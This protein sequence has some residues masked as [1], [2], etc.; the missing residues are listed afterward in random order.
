[1]ASSSVSSQ[2]STITASSS[3]QHVINKKKT[4]TLILNEEAFHYYPAKQP[5][6]AAGDSPLKF[7]FPWTSISKHQVS[8]ASHAKNLLRVLSDKIIEGG[9]NGKKKSTIA[10][11]YEFANRA[12][13]ERIRKDISTRLV[14]S[15]RVQA[16]NNGSLNNRAS[17]IG[18]NQSMS[19]ENETSRKRKLDATNTSESSSPGIGM[20][21]DNRNAD[22][23]SSFTSL[24]QSERTVTCSSILASDQNVRTQ[25]TSLL[26]KAPSATTSLNGNGSTKDS[27]KS[28]T[29]TI[30]EQDFWST[31]RQKLSN[32]SAKI[33]GFV[34][35]GVSS[36][37][38]SSLEIQITGNIS[39]P[40]KLGVEEMR[41]IFI[42][43]PAVHAAYEQ[44]VPL[45]LSE[46]QFWR[47][48]LESEYFHR[49]RGRMG[50]SAKGVDAAEKSREDQ[51]DDGTKKSKDGTTS[52]ADKKLAK[53]EENKAAKEREETA[54]MG[55]A[56]SNDIFSRKD[57]EL[58]RRDAYNYASTSQSKNT[59]NHKQSTKH[60]A[61]G[62]FDLTTTANTERGTK[63]L[64]QSTDLHPSDDR[65]RKVIEKYNR[66]WTMVLNPVDA[67]AGCDL[68]D[69][70]RRSVHH[71]L[72]NDD[73]AKVGG[74]V[75][76]E[77]R[78]LVGYANATDGYVNHVK[79]IGRNEND[80][81][82]SDDALF[83]ELKLKNV[84]A[85]AGIRPG[86][87]QSISVPKEIQ[88]RNAAFAQFALDQMKS[89]IMPLVDY[90][91]NRESTSSTHHI[92]NAFPDVK[93]GHDLL[94][95]L[96]KHM[97]LDAMTD[98]DT[99]KMTRVLSQDFKKRLES[100][101]R[102]SSEL[103]RHFYALRHVIDKEEKL[104]RAGVGGVSAG[105]STMKSSQKL[106][107]I[108]AGMEGVYREMEVMR[109]E[110]PQTDLGEQMRKMCLP[111]MDQ[112]DWAFKLNRDS[113][114][115][116]SGFV[117]VED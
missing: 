101:T 73:D 51:D 24:S 67:T 17:S 82:N 92:S 15:R 78:R 28:S 89:I 96:T 100:F 66:H 83:E 27:A 77:F 34:S 68:N 49:D 46:E 84:D 37:I 35:K 18:G 47:K 106:K 38:K 4:G 103:L 2:P 48:Y 110:Q 44:K 43:Y 72:E 53:E 111:I 107:K 113:S 25:H 87:E 23:S 102:R 20:S 11:T 9:Q 42:M 63:L 98:K 58:K 94:M 65:G 115:S 95:A 56:S 50:S 3:Y 45:E 99:A 114:G 5:G 74:G 10:Q 7:T 86:S 29:C 31:H 85:Y 79:G 71:A 69:L 116:G 32:Q 75:S 33:S 22:K 93:F 55:A 109:K 12:D 70:A 59:V 108:V 21:P 90:K 1:M 76:K 14:N 80:D 52:E 6:E 88:Q 30:A 105:A 97:V 41:Q 36:E 39:K 104:K 91:E 60:I 8:P 61:V 13:L 117:T 62:Q 40:I 112:L 57:V 19:T 26:A 64:L 16:L 54:R 81:G